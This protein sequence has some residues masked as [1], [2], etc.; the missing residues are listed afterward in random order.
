MTDEASKER[1][2]YVDDEELNRMVFQR[3]FRKHF[4]VIATGSGEEALTVMEAH[5]EIR[6]VVTDYKMPEMNGMEFVEAA[7]RRFRGKSY[8]MLSG[9]EA[10]EE[11]REAMA[12]G[13]VERYFQKPLDRQQILSHLL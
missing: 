4:E 5:P 12:R 9:Y 2:L 10:P 7:Q 6:K 11:V 13:V 8:Y 3:C 1:I